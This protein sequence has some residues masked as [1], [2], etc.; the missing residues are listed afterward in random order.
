MRLSSIVFT[1]TVL[2]A[3]N[4]VDV[5]NAAFVAILGHT[6]TSFHGIMYG[7]SSLNTAAAA[8]GNNNVLDGFVSSIQKLMEPNNRVLLQKKK[9]EKNDYDEPI[10]QVLEVLYRAAETKKEDPDEVNEALESLEKLMRKKC[11]AEDGAAQDV[12]DNLNGYW[13]L[14]FTTGTKDSQ[15]KYGAKINYFPIKAV[16]SFNPTADP[17][18]IENGIYVGDFAL[19][20]FFGDF[21]FNLKSRKLEFDF[22]R[23]AILGFG[24]DLGKGKAAQL[25]SASGL[26]SENNEKLIA[27]DK[28]PFFNWISADERI[29]TARG[30]GGGL[31]LWKRNDSEKAGMQG[32][33]NEKA[34]SENMSPLDT[35]TDT[36]PGEEIIAVKSGK[37]IRYDEQAGR[38]FEE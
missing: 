20:K 1:W 9:N 18:Q 30:G 15:K 13:R 26:G 31:A 38:F 8:A 5:T 19:I 33:K 24:I 16:Q 37:N 25:G 23:I 28:K 12:L 2:C 17:F 22:D 3:S 10:Q 7:Y 27:K 29:A 4:V 14:V 21:E 32:L 11:K 36:A 35:N 6:C 34:E